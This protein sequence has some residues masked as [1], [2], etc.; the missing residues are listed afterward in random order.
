MTEQAPSW[1][2][3]RTEAAPA[4]HRYDH[5]VMHKHRAG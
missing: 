3:P 5:I 4:A 1:G 2:L